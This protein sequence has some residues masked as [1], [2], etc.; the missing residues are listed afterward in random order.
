MGDGLFYPD[1][2][3]SRAEFAAIIT[4]ALGFEPKNNAVFSDVS[5]YDWFFGYIGAAYEKGIVSGVSDTLFEPYGEISYEAAATMVERAA[6]L[7]GLD[8]EINASSAKLILSD[9][10]DLVSD[11]AVCSVAFC[12]SLKIIDEGF[13][14]AN[15]RFS[16]SRGEIAQMLCNML[17]E[18]ALL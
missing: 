2:K 7:L 15:P 16:I 13:T 4:G 18:A 11:W 6:R 1:K 10:G 12:K 14:A 8:E 17:K 5:E 3:M 9:Y